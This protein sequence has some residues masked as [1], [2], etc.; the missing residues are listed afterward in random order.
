LAE[1]LP[2]LPIYQFPNLPGRLCCPGLPNHHHLDLP[3]ILQVILDLFGDL[4]GQAEG[5][6]IVNFVGI[7]Q[8]PHFAAGLDGIGLGD[9]REGIA[10]ILKG[11]D[12]LN[13]GL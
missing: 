8:H 11:L 3:W 2:N 7:D 1:K 12:A 9:A 4:F 6:Q 13:L 5:C 10:D